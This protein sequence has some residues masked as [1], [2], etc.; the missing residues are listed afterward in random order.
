M[1]RL[2]VLNCVLSRVVR[3]Y[4]PTATSDLLGV[5]YHQ[6]VPADTE[7]PYRLGT[8]DLFARF[9]STGGFAGRVHVT[10]TRLRPDGSPRERVYWKR[11]PLPV[12]PGPGPMVQD[13]VFRLHGII[14]PGEG[15]YA[16]RIGRASGRRWDG[17]HRRRIL[18][19]DYFEVR[20]AP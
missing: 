18:A 3:R 13:V 2:S 14:A 6:S 9:L 4:G 7:F 10:V 11:H 5:D 1:A 12:V 16:V 15:V 20:K 17:R 8:F 19:T